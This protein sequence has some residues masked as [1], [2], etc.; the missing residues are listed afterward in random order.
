MTTRTS[1]TAETTETINRF[2]EAFNTHDV[3]AIMALMTE[4]VVFENTSPAPDGERYEGQAAVRAF[5]ERLFRA[6]PQAHFA[7]EDMFAAD[8]RCLTRWLYTWVGKDGAKGHVRGVDVFTV[9]DG[10]VSEKL[11]YVKG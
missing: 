3:D 11:S 2:N 10:K 7:T 8:D 6:S 4:D 9:R 1:S 5:W